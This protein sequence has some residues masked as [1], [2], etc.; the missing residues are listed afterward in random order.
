MATIYTIKR[1]DKVVADNLKSEIEAVRWLHNH[2]SCSFDW[3][4]RYEGYSVFGKDTDTG[5]TWRLRPYTPPP[6][7]KKYDEY[8]Y[9]I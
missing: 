6:P 3:A 8:G 4:L 1:D 2:C 7:K 5:E 9:P